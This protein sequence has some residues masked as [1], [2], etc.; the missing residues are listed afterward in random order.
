MIELRNPV[1]LLFIEPTGNADRNLC[2]DNTA[3]FL[4]SQ[5]MSPHTKPGILRVN[6]TFAVGNGYRGFHEA[7]CN[8]VGTLS[9]GQEL[10][11]ANKDYQLPCGLVTNTLSLHYLVY[12][13][14]QVPTSELNKLQAH[15]PDRLTSYPKDSDV[16]MFAMGLNDIAT[17]PEPQAKRHHDVYCDN[18]HAHPI[19]GVRYQCTVCDDF[20]LCANCEGL[21]V[22]V[23]SHPMIK[24]YE[25]PAQYQGFKRQRRHHGAGMR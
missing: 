13:R 12:H 7:T 4:Y 16:L 19:Q 11:S 10:I 21:G 23:K 25:P 18:C 9:S 5:L 1:M 14:S 3:R 24:Y 17:S 6:N 22:H 20:D 2:L 15:M 8:C